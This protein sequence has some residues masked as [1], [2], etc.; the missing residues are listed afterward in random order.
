MA[1]DLELLRN[2]AR[3]NVEESFT[4]LVGRHLNLVYSTALRRVRSPQLA[5]EVAQ[6]AFTDLAR[7]ARRFAPDTVLTAWLYQVTRRTAIDVVRREARRRLR[8]RIATEMNA[9]SAT[10][11]EWTRIEPLLDE[12]MDA[13]DDLDRTAVLLRYF[14]NKSL[15]EVGQTLGTSEDAAQKRVSR[16]V[17]RLREFFSRRGVAVGATGL[18]LLISANATQCA[19]AGLAATVAAAAVLA[20]A[21]VS[22]ST[23]SVATKTIAMTTMQKTIIAA[24]LA[25]AL[26]TG[27]F[28]AWQA[29]RLRNEVRTLQ[30]Q[31]GPLV[32]QIQKLLQERGELTNKVS[33]LLADNER[34]NRNTAEILKL[35]GE[36]AR[37]RPLRNAV[38]T[39]QKAATQSA[40]ALAE[41]KPEEL[42]N[43]GRSTP[44]DALQTYLWSAVTTNVSEL[45]RSITPDDGDPPGEDT[46]RRFVEDARIHPNRSVLEF[47]VVSQTVVSPDE[48]LLGMS[49]LLSEAGG[50]VKTLTL[51]NVNGEWKMVLFN[52]RR[53]GA[54]THGAD[55]GTQTPWP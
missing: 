42:A 48:V 24:A 27:V 1:S 41:W 18:V 15:R 11:T 12:A 40:S 35:R 38:A 5:E 45:A 36:V 25:A 3:N 47:K 50:I 33:A 29:S 28:E 49:A 26:G 7:N 37:L 52:E 34:L 53:E 55:L 19:P 10:A 30:Q 43:V 22:A 23:A 20:G 4:A 31:Q 14:E 54:V 51:R 32:G 9:V 16:A 2:Y 13:L 6:S 21:A 17:E 39:L 46:I 8:E 44:Q